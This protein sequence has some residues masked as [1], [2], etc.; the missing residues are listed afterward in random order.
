MI[1]GGFVKVGSS[2]EKGSATEIW[3]PGGQACDTPD[4]TR[5]R[6]GHAQFTVRDT[7]TVCGG[8]LENTC[9]TLKDGQ[10]RLSHA[11]YQIRD[12]P[13]VWNAGNE[14]YI[15]GGS[16]SHGSHKTTDKINNDGCS[17]VE[18]GFAVRYPGTS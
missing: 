12:R 8:S 17:G 2:W 1:T 13:S 6:W 9:E 14:T 11:L 10:W 5:G 16:H 7:V 18:K 3:S 15:I 4:M